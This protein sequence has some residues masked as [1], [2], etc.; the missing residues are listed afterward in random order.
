MY[1]AA[2]RL[3]GLPTREAEAA[4]PARFTRNSIIRTVG[5]PT[6]FVRRRKKQMFH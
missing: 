4:R 6:A 1:L 5:Q 3:K 2:A